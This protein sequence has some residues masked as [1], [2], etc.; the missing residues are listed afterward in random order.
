MKRL[1][2]ILCLLWP[3]NTWAGSFTISGAGSGPDSLAAT[4]LLGT[5]GADLNHNLGTCYRLYIGY[6]YGRSKILL[7]PDNLTAYMD[8][9]QDYFGSVI[10]DSAKVILTVASEAMI[11]GDVLWI[12][13]FPVIRP[14]VEG[15]ADATCSGGVV[16]CGAT[17]DSAIS[18]YDGGC[19]A[20][21][22]AWGT[23][24][25]ENTTTDRSNIKETCSGV[26]DSVN[27]PNTVAVNDTVVIRIS[28]TTVAAELDEG[29]FL[30]A[31]RS[32]TG[33]YI[34]FYSDD[35]TGDITKR[36][37][38]V[39]YYH[40]DIDTMPPVAIFSGI[41]TSGSS[42]LTVTFTDA[43]R[44]NP[45]SWYWTFGDTWTSNSQ[46]P[47]H[48]YNGTGTYTVTLTATNP[49]GSDVEIKTGYITIYENSRYL[50]VGRNG[51][52]SNSGKSP[53]AAFRTLNKACSTAVAGDT[54]WIMGGVWQDESIPTQWK[55]GTHGRRATLYPRNSGTYAAPI[56]YKSY[57]DSARAIIQG[58]TTLT[59]PS[60]T[61]I[62]VER[63]SHLVFDSLIITKSYRGM[64]IVGNGSDS[65]T[66]KNCVI[67]NTRSEHS[68]NGGAIMFGE[69]F[70]PDDQQQFCTVEACSLYANYNV[71]G[72]SGM[73]NIGGITCYNT[74][75]S[76]FK[77]NV[78]WDSPGGCGIRLKHWCQNDTIRGNI[79][80]DVGWGI[81]VDTD[82]RH[83]VTC[84][85]VVYDVETGYMQREMKYSAEINMDNKTYNNTIW[86]CHNEGSDGSGINIGQWTA[87]DLEGIHD[88]Q[89]FNNIVANI[90][91]TWNNVFLST[92]YSG[93]VPHDSIW[94]N[95]NLY[96]N[97]GTDTTIAKWKGTIYGLGTFKAVEHQDSNSTFENP[98]FVDTVNHDFHID[99]AGPAASGGRGGSW[100]T[101]RGAYAPGPGV[102]PIAAFFGIPTSG[103]VP[104]TVN[105][106]DQSNRSPTSWS[107][108]FGD[109]TT[110]NSAQNPSHEYE[111]EGMYT[112]TLTV[113]NS[114]G[115]DVLVK[116]DYIIAVEAVGAPI[117]APIGPRSGREGQSLG[118]RI[119]ATDP[120]MTIP[121]LT[122][123]SVPTHATFVD[124]GN[125]A[126]YFA[127]TP[128]TTQAGVFY[129][130]FIASDGI[131]ADSELVAITIA[132]WIPSIAGMKTVYDYLY[133]GDADTTICG[134]IPVNVE[135]I[136]PPGWPYSPYDSTTG[137]RI[138]V[139]PKPTK[140]TTFCRFKFRLFPNSVIK[141]DSTRWH[142][143]AKQGGQTIYNDT[144]YL[145]D[146]TTQQISAIQRGQ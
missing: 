28:G 5:S 53:S 123:V 39:V 120:D 6:Y 142:F 105:F 41:P 93:N 71:P 138:V 17:M 22:I 140:T 111:S 97:F 82:A 66:I 40:G 60:R 51:N 62:I 130:R 59:G 18:Y 78:I 43:S 110:H 15:Y 74:N 84:F 131:L 133:T 21:N 68:E 58:D 121:T 79:V 113:T 119:S 63:R 128:D 95:N 102:A 92:V 100:P 144:V 77:N 136:V 139:K 76:I 126:G 35:Y 32:G 134:G 34:S 26:I 19:G 87:S 107:W 122:A 11:S 116:T 46:N 38:F 86:N 73:E 65:I 30:K 104:L 129:V 42:P 91:G 96:W 70:P 49:Y 67:H 27:V 89:V 23:Q 112:V 7:R 3:A 20:S 90:S 48:Q 114:H 117:L 61:S 98:L 106:T 52:N 54:V 16:G 118:F 99:S 88:A 57:R 33:P 108:N 50:Y 37:K 115:N 2:I 45:T 72:T 80:H 44:H 103:S 14:W 81:R 10:Y 56:V 31:Y 145:S 124:S 1:L 94:L 132:S 75:N 4:T 125:G 8:T 47:S 127:F 137:Y 135:L 9:V 101:Y 146:T 64:W 29:L 13:T 55:S 25:C 36:P 12:S 143:W 141:P 109:D 69:G 24:G 83:N 85:N